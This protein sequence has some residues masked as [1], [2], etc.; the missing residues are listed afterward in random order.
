[1]KI[2]E[3]FMDSSGMDGR[4][5]WSTRLWEKG[6]NLGFAFEGEGLMGIDHTVCVSVCIIVTLWEAFEIM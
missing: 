2:F 6:Q 5:K 3:T 1:M 4:S